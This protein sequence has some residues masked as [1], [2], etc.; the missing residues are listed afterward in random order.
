VNTRCPTYVGY[1]TPALPA[2]C[3]LLAGVGH[4]HTG[5]QG[6]SCWRS[7]LQ[8]SPY[9]IA[10]ATLSIRPVADCN[11][12]DLTAPDAQYRKQHDR[13]HMVTAI[14]NACMPSC[15]LPC[16]WP[17]KSGPCAA[18]HGQSATS[19]GANHGPRLQ[20]AAVNLLVLP[21]LSPLFTPA[22]VSCFPARDYRSPCH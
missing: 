22:L 12:A 4:R 19:Y 21:A 16:V 9:I 8:S 5:C 15:T 20:C 14:S 17:G 10:L 7:P 18:D 13:V 2:K 11:A 6:V 1:H 3:E